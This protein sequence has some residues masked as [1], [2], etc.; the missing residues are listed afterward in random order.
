MRLVSRVLRDIQLNQPVPC[1]RASL[2]LFYSQPRAIRVGHGAV[3][4]NHGIHTVSMAPSQG[5]VITDY[6]LIYPELSHSSKPSIKTG[7]TPQQPTSGSLVQESKAFQRWSGLLMDPAR[8]AVESDFFRQGPAKDLD[9]RLLVDRFENYGDLALWTC[10]LD[11]QM[12]VNGPAGVLHV[13]KALWGRKTLYDVDSPLAGMFWRIILEGALMSDDPSILE[14]IWIYSEWMFDLHRVKWPQLYTT[15]ISHLLLT[16]QHQRVLQWHLRMTPNFYPGP[17]E[18]ATIIRQFALDKE[19]YQLDTLPSLYKT[20]PKKK[21]YNTLLPYL[22]D[23]GESNL[24][25]QWRRIFIRHG[26]APLA[27]MPVRPFLRFLAGYHPGDKLTPEELAAL[28]FTAAPMNEE[29]KLSREFMNHVHGKTFGIPI[30]SFND[31]MGARWFASSWV[32]LDTA[33]ASISAL[34]IEQIGPLSLQSIALRAGGSKDLLHRISQLREYGISVVKSNYFQLILYLV[35]LNDDELLHDLLQSDLHPDV[36]DDLNLQTRLIDSTSDA[37]DWR[38]LRLLMVSRLVVCHQSAREAANS[39]LGARFLRRDQDGV[40]QILRDMKAG[41]IPLKVEAANLIYDNLIEDYNCSRRILHPQPA[42]FYLS[43]FLQL[44]SM[45]VPVPLSHWKLIMLSMARGGRLEELEKLCT[46][47][48]DT[49]IHTP[50][51]RPGFV[52]I[53]ICDLPEAMK[54]PLGG[55]ENL[56]GVYIPQDLP[57]S[58]GS[59]PLR[60]LFNSKV[61]TN[62]IENAFIAHPGQGFRA[63]SNNQSHGSQSQASQIASMIR[64]LRALNQ[65]GMWIRFRKIR[66]VIT[67]CLVTIYG[68]T[69]PTETPKRLMRWSNTLSPKEMKTLIDKAW[70]GNFLPSMNDLAIIIK[71]RPPG[72]SLDSRPL[73][74]RTKN[75]DKEPLDD[76]AEQNQAK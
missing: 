20:S 50:S 47:L 68:P 33:I 72:L 66:F 56:L 63:V 60:E 5:S 57:T 1:L 53:H 40:L 51:L 10:L 27:P 45:D 58:H 23:L 59:H 36:F 32:S 35:K 76:E 17:D 69:F 48:V 38:T 52:P 70:G 15:V 61:I 43:I 65:K 55:V 73:Q 19:L 16:H 67:N 26:E 71:T 18:F 11:Y 34:G 39:V 44:K 41:N 6:D 28:D 37:G 49:F 29:P 4:A 46:E 42:A 8:L 7:V 21:L 24:A 12:R 22:F 64:L 2:A 9:R 54:G 14:N 75:E 62:M 30:K 25:R 74:Y 13:W 3:R 31:R